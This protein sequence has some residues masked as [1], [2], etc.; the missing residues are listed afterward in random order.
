MALT[1]FEIRRRPKH[2]ERPKATFE[3]VRLALAY[4]IESSKATTLL[5]IGACDGVTGDPAHDFIRSGRFRAFL[6][7][8]IDESFKALGRTYQGVPNVT[9]IRAA[10]ANADGELAMYKVREGAA[11][12]RAGWSPQYSSFDRGHLLRHDVAP[13]DIQQVSVPCMTL[14]S[15]IKKH[16]I[17]H[18]EILLSDA[19]GFDAEVVAMAL[20]LPTPPECISFES[21]HLSPARMSELFTRL[22]RQNYVWAHDKWN[23]LA[24][25]ET[26]AGRW[27]AAARLPHPQSGGRAAE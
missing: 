18:V 13:E 21:F 23:T 10:L 22:E 8:P 7:E 12:I 25:G 11:S 16:G 3:N 9:L 1:P 4:Y 2:F 15:L 20:S 14:D 24:I 17:G 19:E 26:L 6:V 27:S 5:Q